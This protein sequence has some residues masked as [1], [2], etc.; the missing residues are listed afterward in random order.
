MPW[1]WLSKSYEKSP[2]LLGRTHL[3]EE[4]RP[5]PGALLLVPGVGG[6]CISLV[7]ELTQHATVT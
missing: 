3:L 2:C 7:G 4:A 5:G 6:I 1:S